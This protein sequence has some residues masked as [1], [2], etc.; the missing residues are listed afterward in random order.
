MPGLLGKNARPSISQPRP[1]ATM[2]EK[3]AKL[4]WRY[5]SFAPNSERSCNSGR[6]SQRR[7]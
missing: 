2:R 4:I 6:S 1:I 7:V 5:G 3:Q